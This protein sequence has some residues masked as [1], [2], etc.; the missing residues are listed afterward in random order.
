MPAD[1]FNGMALVLLKTLRAG[2]QLAGRFAVFTAKPR[3]L[4]IEL[5]R[6]GEDRIVLAGDT[7]QATRYL[8]HLEIGGI[9]G[10]LASLL[11]KTP[12]DLRYWLDLGEVPAFVRFEGSMFLKGPVWRVELAGVDEP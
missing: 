12:P 7:K 11:E 1:L 2:E 10:L 8:V 6:E 3:L 9:T 5:R 4:R